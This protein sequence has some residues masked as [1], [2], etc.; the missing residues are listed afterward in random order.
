M[1]MNNIAE[2]QVVKRK[3]G[4]PRKNPLPPAPD[5][6][7]Q[8]EAVKDIVKKKRAANYPQIIENKVAS[9]DVQKSLKSVL[10]WYGREIVKSDDECAERV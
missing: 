4:R 1:E 5:P 3:P 7:T 9:A 10:R 2:E 8:D 6:P